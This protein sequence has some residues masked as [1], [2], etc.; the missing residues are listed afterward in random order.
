M[1]TVGDKPTNTAPICI[2]CLTKSIVVQSS[3]PS[4]R[5]ISSQVSTSSVTHHISPGGGGGGDREH[6]EK[7]Q[8]RWCKW[9][10]HHGNKTRGES[11]WNLPILP[12]MHFTCYM[13][14]HAH[15]KSTADLEMVKCRST[16]PIRLTSPS[17]ITRLH[18]YKSCTFSLL[19]FRLWRTNWLT[20]KV[21]R[22]N[23]ASTANSN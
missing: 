22:P 1:P 14:V 21:S 11:S 10:W 4:S 19:W 20:P 18:V 16:S 15:V 8:R 7:G 17:D 23:A 9:L 6:G 12:R 2:S 5:C 3:G 13:H